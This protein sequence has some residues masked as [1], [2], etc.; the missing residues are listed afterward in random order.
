MTTIELKEQL[1]SRIS[2]L[3]DND[4]LMDVYKL[5]ENCSDDSEIYNLT[6]NHKSAIAT[7]INQINN[8][9]FLTNEQANN[10]IDAWLN[11]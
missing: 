7:A 4:L 1:I 9:D 8:G 10:E 11:K 5:L 2:Q 3:S 6:D